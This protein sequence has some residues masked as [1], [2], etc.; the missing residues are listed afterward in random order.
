M[1]AELKNIYFE[2]PQSELPSCQHKYEKAQVMPEQSI[3]AGLDIKNKLAKEKMHKCVL[4]LMGVFSMFVTTY[5]LACWRVS[6]TQKFGGSH[7]KSITVKQEKP[8][9]HSPH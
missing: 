9:G 1:Q 7:L 2:R 8:L 6:Q 3:T 4:I 5:P